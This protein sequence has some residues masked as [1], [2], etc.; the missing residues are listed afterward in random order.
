MPGGSDE[1]DRRSRTRSPPA[2]RG[3]ARRSYDSQGSGSTGHVRQGRFSSDDVPKA[4]TIELY[5]VCTREDWPGLHWQLVNVLALSHAFVRGLVNTSQQ[6]RAIH[7]AEEMNTDEQQEE[8]WMDHYGA[9][10]ERLE[11]VIYGMIQTCMSGFTDSLEV[12]ATVRKNVPRCAGK[13]WT[14]LLLKYPL[15]DACTK[16]LLLAREISHAVQPNTS[17][18][19]AYN[20]HSAA[21]AT[22]LLAIQTDTITP[23]DLF[24]LV[25]MALYRNSSDKYLRKAFGDIKRA[26]Q[27][28]DALSGT[29]VHKHVKDAIRNRKAGKDIKAFSTSTDGRCHECKGCSLHCKDH[30]GKWPPDP[31][32]YS[33]AGDSDSLSSRRNVRRDSRAPSRDIKPSLMRFLIVTPPSPSATGIQSSP[34]PREP[35][36][37]P[38]SCT[39]PLI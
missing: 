33:S 39:W 7:T 29:L 22:Q 32:S 6:T 1:D 10:Y 14:A 3:G 37:R 21:V 27:E 25:E 13:L 30:K 9:D 20:I 34:T 38:T 19:D 4:S 2:A 28:G 36:R 8:L 31:S 26:L 11:A 35:P 15:D 18:V 16:H 12:F 24:A 23:A 17:S 5:W